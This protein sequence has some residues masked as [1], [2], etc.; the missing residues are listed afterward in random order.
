MFQL[1]PATPVALLPLAATMP[2]TC[3]PCQELLPTRQPRKNPDG[4]SALLTPSPGSAALLSPQ[5]PPIYGGTDAIQHNIIGER[6]LG[7]PKEPSAD[8]G[9]AF[10]ELPKNG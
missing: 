10:R 5:G 3:V 6:V 2:L 9:K 1:T 4:A 8:K 7:L